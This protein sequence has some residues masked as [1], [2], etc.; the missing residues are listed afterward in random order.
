MGFGAGHIL[1]MNQRIRQNRELRTSR[2]KRQQRIN[3]FSSHRQSLKLKFKTL[4]KEEL[5]K[6]KQ[7]IRKQAK[8]EQ[9]KQWLILSVF[10]I[11]GIIGITLF[12]IWMT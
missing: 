7:E 1:D 8:Y 2:K 11:I 9:I 6:A 3:N 12:I 10:I 4:S 5:E